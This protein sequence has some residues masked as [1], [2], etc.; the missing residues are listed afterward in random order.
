MSAA[1]PKLEDLREARAWLWWF[2]GFFGFTFIGLYLCVI[3]VDPFAT[4]RF[5]LTQRIDI[6][7]SISRLSKPGIV[8]DPQFNAA[9]FGSSMGIPLDPVKVGAR[10]NWRIAQLAIEAALP[11]DQLTVARAFERRHQTTPALDI[12]V[13]DNLWCRAGDPSSGAFGPFPNWLYESSDVEYLSRIL[14]PVAV[15]AMI[16]RIEIWFGITGQ[17]GRLDGFAYDPPRGG[18][19]PPRGLQRPFAGP[20]ADTA[21]PA[22]DALADHVAKRPATSPIAFIFAPAY[23]ASL[24]E[25][26][27]AAAQRLQACKDRARSIADRPNTAFL[28]FMTDN[29]VIRDPANF[30]YDLHYLTTVANWMEPQIARVLAGLQAS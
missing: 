28:D 30:T 9:I 6:A 20:S 16:V 4:G 12:F 13:L 29:P 7:S 25:D 21:F 24:P 8:R 3:L 19:L 26:G 10:A 2:G 14:S 5:A 23:I 1:A 11:P 15:E 17:R 18:R 27:S 22:L